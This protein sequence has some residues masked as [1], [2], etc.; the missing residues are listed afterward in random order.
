[1]PTICAFRGIRIFINWNDHLPPH[2][3]A[4]YAG[5]SVLVDIKKIDVLEGNISN[6][7]LK[8]LLGWTAL[9]QEEL[10]ENWEL[11]SKGEETFT[12]TPLA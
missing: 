5:D 7:Q 8:M 2:F 3:H 9:H 11:A 4:E 1:M 6:K 10:L 12:I